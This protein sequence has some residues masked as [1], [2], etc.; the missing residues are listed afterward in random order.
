MRGWDMPR[1]KT[2][3][4]EPP[5]T[6]VTRREARDELIAASVPAETAEQMLADSRR[7]GSSG[8]QKYH[9]KVTC[10][11]PDAYIVSVI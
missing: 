2:P 4:P 5:A 9:R 1:K 11:A 8:L 10:I 6:P 3:E 7:A